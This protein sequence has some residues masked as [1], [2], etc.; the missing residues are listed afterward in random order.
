MS[1]LSENLGGPQI[2][3]LRSNVKKA[4]IQKVNVLKITQLFY[5]SCETRYLP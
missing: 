5:S 2:V 1:G 3:N 4:C